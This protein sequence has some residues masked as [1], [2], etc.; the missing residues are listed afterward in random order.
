MKKTTQKN[1]LSLL[2]ILMTLVL[3]LTACGES[4]EPEASTDAL[5]QETSVVGYYTGNIGSMTAFFHF[6]EDGTYYCVFYDGGMTD[7]GTYTVVDAALDYYTEYDGDAKEFVE[8]SKKTADKY[9]ELTSYGDGVTENQL[10]LVDNQIAS[11]NT[12]MTHCIALTKDDSFNDP[13]GLETN[14]RYVIAQLYAENNSVK[15]FTLYHDMSY[16]DLTGDLMAD[17]TFTIDGDGVYT[18]TDSATNAVS[19]L[20][21]KEDGTAVLKAGDEEKTLRSAILSDRVFEGE[22]ELTTVVGETIDIIQGQTASV[23]L[24]C[25]AADGTYVL[26]AHLEM[27]SGAVALDFVLDEGTYVE[28]TDATYMDMIPTFEFTS[29]NAA[30]KYTIEREFDAATYTAIYTVTV[31]LSEAETTIPFNGFDFTPAVSGEG[32][33]TLTY[34]VQL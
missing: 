23:V 20:T 28:G 17:G 13:N 4:K 6:N 34:T 15:V 21:V 8:A 29:N 31:T 14:F 2:A 10:P 7:A 5:P 1:L 19:T 32:T 12:S 9:I 18:L 16:E 30:N 26:N 3:A 11:V 27:Y 22:F 24:N 33:V 25:N